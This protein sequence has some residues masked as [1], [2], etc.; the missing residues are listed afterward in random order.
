MTAIR[1]RP[2]GP[3]ETARRLQ[4][5]EAELARRGEPLV[6]AE[7]LIGVLHGVERA[8][9]V[10]TAVDM[11]MVQT[12]HL[13]QLVDEFRARSALLGLMT[14]HIEPLEKHSN[15]RANVGMSNRRLIQPFPSVFHIAAAAVVVERLEAKQTS[16]SRLTRDP[17]FAA[18]DLHWQPS[19]WLNINS[20][21][22]VEQ[23]NSGGLRIMGFQPES[24]IQPPAGDP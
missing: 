3:P 20:P 17:L 13:K 19:T 1:R 10:V 12:I 16:V 2:F 23:M 14:W 18:L 9:V 15:V 7:L 21:A 22:Q 24:T 4:R 5:G 6:G 11:P 8:C